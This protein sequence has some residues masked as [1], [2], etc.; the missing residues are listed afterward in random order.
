[1][2]VGQDVLLLTPTAPDSGGWDRYGSRNE[3]RRVQTQ[4]ANLGSCVGSDCDVS[5]W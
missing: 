1:M 4:V 5:S 3:T 2:G